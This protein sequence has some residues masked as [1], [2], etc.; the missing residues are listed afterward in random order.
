VQATRRSWAL[1]EIIV[2]LS[3]EART[4]GFVPP[5]LA[6][7]VFFVPSNTM[8]CMAVQRQCGHVPSTLCVFRA[9]T[10]I[11]GSIAEFIAGR[12]GIYSV[13]K[14]AVETYTDSLTRKMADTAVNVRVVEPGGPRSNFG[15]NRA[16]HAWPKS[17]TRRFSA[18]CATLPR[19]AHGIQPRFEDSGLQGR[20]FSAMNGG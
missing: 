10:R 17:Q 7:L 16:M 6:R 2:G 15:T 8:M 14:F 4:R 20:M 5:A 3:E 1:R 19:Y 18:R 12:S 13:S 9:D 11:I